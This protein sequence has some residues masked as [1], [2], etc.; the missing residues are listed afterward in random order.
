MNEKVSIIMPAYNSAR[1]IAESIESVIAQTYTNWE[2]LITDD[3]SKDDSYNIMMKYAEK[4]SRIQIYQTPQ[5]SGAAV[6]RNISLAHAVGKYIAFLDS[7]DLW[8]NTKLER[9]VAFM[10]ERDIAF[11]FSDYDV[12]EEDGKPTGNIVHTPKAIGYHGYLRNTIIGCLTVMIDKSKTGEFEM[13][14]IKSSHDMA[15]WLLIMK[16][17]FKAY[18]MQETL[19]HYRLVSTSN[20]AKKWKAAKDVWKV[21]REIEH[22]NPVYSAF[23]FAGYAI[24]AILKRL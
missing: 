14:N 13:P 23:C 11:S 4:D 12:I 1:F 16:R 21:Y 22:I 17:G 8:I 7:D 9:Q 3:C 24:N 18:A 15:L 19:A 20:T 10:E 5:N 2:L 6:A